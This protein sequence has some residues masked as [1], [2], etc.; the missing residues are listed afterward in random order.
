MKAQDHEARSDE[1]AE[2]EL[3]A[4]GRM[5]QDLLGPA[6]ELEAAEAEER[7]DRGRRAE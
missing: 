4:I 7:P 3:G 5:D 6:E 2:R 1:S